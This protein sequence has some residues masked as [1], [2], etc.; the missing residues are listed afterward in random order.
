MLRDIYLYKAIFYKEQKDFYNAYENIKMHFRYRDTI[1]SGE[2][3]TKIAELQTQYDTE[4]KDFEITRLSADQQIKQ[5]ELEKQQAVIAGNKEEAK[6][7]QNE[8]DLLV[9]GRELQQL[10]I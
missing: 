4:K 5:L 1:T 9:Q 2:T 3:Q 8:I 6:R 7:K 10:K